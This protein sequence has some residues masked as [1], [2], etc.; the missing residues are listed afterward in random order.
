M[1]KS[2]LS[3]PPVTMVQFLWI[4]QHAKPVS[5]T[6]LNDGD[7]KSL[8]SFVQRQRPPIHD[9]KKQGDED[10]HSGVSPQGGDGAHLATQS[11]GVGGAL[12]A[13][14]HRAGMQARW[15]LNSATTAI[16]PRKAQ[17]LLRKGNGSLVV[18][19]DA[20]SYRSRSNGP[21]WP[22]ESRSRL[23]YATGGNELTK[24]GKNWPV[25]LMLVSEYAHSLYS[26]YH[27]PQY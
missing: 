25:D 11:R 13:R 23:E 22:R 26:R 5:L 4:N 16:K 18:P 14:I 10:L 24:R 6:R 15:R 7:R 3:I 19:E 12:R 20:P 9:E 8:R 27:H 21:R 1:T 17:V 2:P